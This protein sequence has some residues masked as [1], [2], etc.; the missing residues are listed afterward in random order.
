MDG[1][2][3]RGAGVDDQARLESACSLWL[4][5]VRIPPSPPFISNDSQ[6]RDRHLCLGHLTRNS[7]RLR[8]ANM[9]IMLA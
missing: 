5:W 8:H 3:R 4:P 2:I 6:R 9:T 7:A 1:E